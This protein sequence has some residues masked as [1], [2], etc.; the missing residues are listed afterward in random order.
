MKLF[1]F[2]KIPMGTEMPAAFFT[3]IVVC[4]DPDSPEEIRVH[5]I[6]GFATPML[7]KVDIPYPIAGPGFVIRGWGIFH[8]LIRKTYPTYPGDFPTYCYKRFIGVDTNPES[9]LIHGEIK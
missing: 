9:K 7:K 2:G 1:T 4:I 8:R 6:F 3:N 5:R